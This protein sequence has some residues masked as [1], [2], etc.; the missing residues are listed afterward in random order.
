MTT[1]YTYLIG[2]SKLDLWYYGVR[3]AKGCNPS[4]LWGSYFTSSSVVAEM[5]LTHGEP[6]VVEARKTFSASL[7]AR[8]WEEKVIDR[9]KCVE[10]PRWLNRHNRGRHFA[11]TGPRS[12]IHKERLRKANTGKKYGPP[13]P[14]HLEKLR[15]AAK[16]KW[17]D[18]DMVE[19]INE[20]RRLVTST[21]EYKENHLAAMKSLRSDPAKMAD[22]GKKISEANRGK[23]RTDEHRQRYSLAKK[24]KPG[25]MWTDE[26]RAAVSEKRKG[27]PR[28]EATKE[29]IKQSW[30]A[31]KAQHA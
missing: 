29:K 31:R 14:E 6:D 25:R 1:P 20:S 18:A 7:D 11:Q 5:R 19:K 26:Q 28:S 21:V 17:Q 12:E 2:W 23:A 30:I 13:S 15:I 10:S 9:M 4:D 22:I 8:A 16:A 3:W 27:V 24:G